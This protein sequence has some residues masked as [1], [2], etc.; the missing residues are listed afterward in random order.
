[1]PMATPTATFA[2]LTTMRSDRKTDTA[3]CSAC[4]LTITS[5]SK[6]GLQD[7]DISSLLSLGITK[8]GVNSQTPTS[9]VWMGSDGKFTNE[10]TNESGENMVL[11]VWGVAGSWV[12]G[13]NPVQPL[14]TVSLAPNEKT[15]LSFAE[16]ASGGWAGIYSDTTVNLGQ[17]FNTWGEFTFGGTSSTVD[18]SREV[19]MNGR[20]MT[21]VT[22]GC[23]S[24]MNTC[25]FVCK[26]GAA[27][28]WLE[29]ELLNCHAGNGGGSDAA[30]MNG[31]CNGIPSTGAALKTYM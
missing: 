10:F 4:L 27:S 2:A 16:G 15:T 6:R 14:I 13:L 29:Y 31:G 3:R 28:C 25:V 7:R 22:P 19:F 1:M 18:V 8:T 12:G 5:L 11:V 21:I 26:N 30:A 20:N 9:N 23:V 17:I 24:D